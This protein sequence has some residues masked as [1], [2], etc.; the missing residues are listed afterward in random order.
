MS[1]PSVPPH[2]SPRAD[3]A[4]PDW[5]QP[6]WLDGLGA[7]AEQAIGL[8]EPNPR[9]ACRIICRD[10]RSFSG[11][12]QH[13][14]GAHAEVMALHAARAAG[15]P[16][17]GASAIVTLEPC[18][19]HGRTPPCCDALIAA[20]LARVL[21]ALRDPNPLVAG[22]GI[23]RLRA[24]GV[25]VDVLPE[26]HPLAQEAR[27]LN[28]GFLS[29]MERG[30][31]W[32]RLK[33]AA[34]LDGIT[35]LPN[36]ASQ[37]I[38]SPEARADGHAWRKRAGAVLSGS[39]TLR[40][41][42]PR[43]DVRLVPTAQQPLRVLLDSHLR[44]PLQARVLQPPGRVLIYHQNLDAPW[45]T[46]AAAANER[47]AFQQR[48]AA[49]QAQG[50]SLIA[51]PSAAA[52]AT[53][54]HPPA[55]WPGPDG[56]PPSGEL[57]LSWVL[58]DLAQ[59]QQV[60]ELHLEAGARLNGAFLRAQL[61]DEVLLYLA[62]LLLGQGQGLAAFGPLRALEQGV[63]LQFIETLPLGRDLRLRARVS[64]AAGGAF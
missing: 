39:G 61:V 30:R 58:H 62:P 23:E 32:V 64:P 10:G 52:A 49:L 1:L 53:G 48:H 20:G 33:V 55:P 3:A 29:R 16:L 12:T 7:L 17:Q 2:P 13:A 51:A 63:A 9:V 34:S 41:D 43:L 6:H 24:A 46:H 47:L 54:A 45:A 21:V 22:R 26:S 25:H 5:V 28:L 35:A 56:L 8:S 31:P 59:Q 19:H 18:S 50:A 38:T 42:D 37:W 4:L 15:A 44:T 11:H 60:N 36:G 57:D 14:G 27:A 40:A